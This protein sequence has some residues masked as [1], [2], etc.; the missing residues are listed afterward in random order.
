[1]IDERLTSDLVSCIALSTT[2]IT[3]PNSSATQSSAPLFT[4]PSIAFRAPTLV[5]HPFDSSRTSLRTC[6]ICLVPSGAEVFTTALTPPW[7]EVLMLWVLSIKI[8]KRLGIHERRSPSDPSPKPLTSL[9]TRIP[10]DSLS[11]ACLLSLHTL[12]TSGIW[13]ASKHSACV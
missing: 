2:G 4:S 6:I 10:A 1:M 9:S 11:A 3:P 8:S 7:A 5:L 12:T 13:A